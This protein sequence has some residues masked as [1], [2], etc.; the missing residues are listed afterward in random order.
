MRTTTT[1]D[2][3]PLLSLPLFSL[4]FQL[5]LNNSGPFALDAFLGPLCDDR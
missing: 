5:S 1:I 2:A 4:V 3:D